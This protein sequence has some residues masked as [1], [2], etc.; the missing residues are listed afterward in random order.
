MSITSNL[1]CKVRWRTGQPVEN[2]MI[3]LETITK[4]TTTV[5]F[6]AQPAGILPRFMDINP[7]SLVSLVEMP[8]IQTN[9]DGIVL[10]SMRNQMVAMMNPPRLEFQDLSQEEPVRPDFAGRVARIMEQL[11]ES[12]DF[13]ITAAGITFETG[14]DSDNTELPSQEMRNFVNDDL[15]AG[16]RYQT[17]GASL[18]F[19]YSHGTREYDLR[20]E[21]DGNQREGQ[22]Y[23]FRLHV[24][25]ASFPEG[26]VREEWLS[27]NLRKEY[28]DFKTVLALIKS[29]A[30]EKSQ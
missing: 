1:L 9:S 15:F 24:H 17:I 21:P 8:D 11:G 4:L 2:R 25:L 7:Q 14:A 5:V 27:E 19:W 18:R 13:A 16:T 20:L 30:K 6:I 29:R 10:S 26:V 22:G 12:N 28:N 3:A 23:F